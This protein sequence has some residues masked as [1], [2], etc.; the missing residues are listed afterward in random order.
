MSSVFL[1]KE[2]PMDQYL[3]PM[4]HS[5][6]YKWRIVD[7]QDHLVPLD[8]QPEVLQRMFP[9]NYNNKIAAWRVGAPE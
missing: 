7:S 5:L 9:T 1:I 6:E 3:D 2:Q 4:V 8:R